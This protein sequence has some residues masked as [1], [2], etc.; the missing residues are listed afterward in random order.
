MDYTLHW[1]NLWN[2]TFLLFTVLYV[3]PRTNPRT[4]RIQTADFITGV[5]G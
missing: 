4:K 5:Q 3:P 1:T 2:R